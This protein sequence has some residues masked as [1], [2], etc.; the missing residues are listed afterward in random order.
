[1]SQYGLLKWTFHASVLYKGLDVL[2]E[3]MTETT[4]KGYYSYEAPLA[5]EEARVALEAIEAY[6]RSLEVELDAEHI[7]KQRA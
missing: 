6:I 4:L 1:M 7:Q 3:A 2:E 5:I